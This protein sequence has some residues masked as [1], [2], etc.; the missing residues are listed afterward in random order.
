MNAANFTAELGQQQFLNLLVTQLQHQDPLQ[1]VDQQEFI[2]QLAQ[3]SVV[4]GLERLN[5]RFDDL[6]KL[7]TL[8]QGADLAGR[9]VEYSSL[10]GELLTG[11]VEES[12]V[13]D[14]KLV[15][16][17]NGEPVELQQIHAILADAVPA[18]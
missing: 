1:P 4:E 15:V 5:V 6:V 9:V 12:R 11:R 17:I 10:S 16:S 18:E 7:Q 14:G 8:S 3:F 2:S 13:V